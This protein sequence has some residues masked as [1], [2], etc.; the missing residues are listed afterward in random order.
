MP[1]S[2]ETG[3]A[4]PGRHTVY[5]ARFRLLFCHIHD[6]KIRLLP[7]IL[8]LLLRFIIVI[9]EEKGYRHLSPIGCLP[10]LFR[11][12]VRECIRLSGFG[13]SGRFDIISSPSARN[14]TSFI[15]T[16]RF[17]LVILFTF[18][19]YKISRNNVVFRIGKNKNR[20]EEK[21]SKNNIDSQGKIHKGKSTRKRI[22]VTI[23]P[24]CL[25][26]QIPEDFSTQ[27]SLFPLEPKHS[28]AG[29]I[30]LTFSLF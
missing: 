4:R 15:I 18:Y 5:P 1:A 14:L 3:A 9:G 10:P 2:S 30:L 16:I 22:T 20:Y 8:I 19:A 23:W 26:R 7:G 28:N 6:L 17:S 13:F 25:D 24:G 29:R 12:L 11:H 27:D 21:K